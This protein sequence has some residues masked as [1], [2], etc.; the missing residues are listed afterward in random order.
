VTAGR[1]AASDSDPP[2]GHPRPVPVSDR[3]LPRRGP[4]PQRFTPERDRARH[5]YACHPFGGGPRACIGQHFSLLESTIALA[6]LVHNF[7][8]ATAG[9]QP[10][11]TSH[12]TLRPTG[13]VPVVVQPRPMANAAAGS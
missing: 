2:V 5:R 13:T 3:C 12:I 4:S 7:T 11:Y 1:P 6:G 10:R 8:F 9:G